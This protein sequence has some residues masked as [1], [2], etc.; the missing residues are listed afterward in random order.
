MLS[1]VK[2]CDEALRHKAAWNWINTFTGK[3][4]RA[5]GIIPADSS[6]EW[7]HGWQN[8]FETLSNHHRGTGL[9]S[10]ALRTG[11]AL[12]LD[13]VMAESVKLP[14]LREELLEVLNAV[15]V[16]DTVPEEWHLPALIPIP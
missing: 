3:K 8:H 14:E 16:S 5:Q 9:S 10:E 1:E 11:H 6:T 13:Q 12:G 15:Y 7:L 2:C 4:A